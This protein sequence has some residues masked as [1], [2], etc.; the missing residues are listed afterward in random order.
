MYFTWQMQEA[1][2]AKQKCKKQTE[3]I[4]QSDRIK[5][6]HNRDNS[7]GNCFKLFCY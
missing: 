3:D 1:K 5:A 4:K 7:I 2:V 6:T